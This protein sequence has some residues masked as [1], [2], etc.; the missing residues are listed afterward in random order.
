MPTIAAMVCNGERPP[1]PPDCPEQFR[2]LMADCLAQDK[3]NRPEFSKILESRIFDQCNSL[4]LFLSLSLSLSLC[5]CACVCVLCVCFVCVFCVCVLC[6]VCVFC[7]CVCMC[8]LL[9]ISECPSLFPNT[10][11]LEDAFQGECVASHF[12]FSLCNKVSFFF[13]HLLAAD[14]NSGRM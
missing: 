8:V 5:V 13:L 12:W 3:S 9:I 2:R 1:I 10:V 4:F 14:I 11:I 7:M 6:V